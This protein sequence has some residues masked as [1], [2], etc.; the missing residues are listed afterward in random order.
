MA[1][2]LL[3]SLRA[4]PISSPGPISPILQYVCVLCVLWIYYYR[5]ILFWNAIKVGLKWCRGE[6]RERATRMSSLSSTP[7]FVWVFSSHNGNNTLTHS[8]THAPSIQ[9]N[10]NCMLELFYFQIYLPFTLFFI[11]SFYWFHGW[12]F[13]GRPIDIIVEPPFANWINFKFSDYNGGSGSGSSIYSRRRR[14]HEKNTTSSTNEKETSSSSIENE[15]LNEN[16]ARAHA[17][18]DEGKRENGKISV[19]MIFLKIIIFLFRVAFNR[20]MPPTFQN[21]IHST[22]M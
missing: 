18:H 15:K 21:S 6:H 7:F 11:L 14:W 9:T 19:W 8:H 20:W 12:C 10:P 4:R 17:L 1:C 16:P 2:I 5:C 22:C 13:I 3:T